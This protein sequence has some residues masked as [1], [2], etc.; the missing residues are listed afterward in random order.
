MDKVGRAL[1]GPAEIIDPQGATDPGWKAEY[2]KKW[3]NFLK[4]KHQ[5]GEHAQAD[6]QK[7][8]KVRVLSA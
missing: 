8:K 7:R 2:A 4:L 3:R 1:T 5:G 6:N